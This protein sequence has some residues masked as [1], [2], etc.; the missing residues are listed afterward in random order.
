MFLLRRLVPEKVLGGMQWASEL[1]MKWFYTSTDDD[2]VVHTAKL[3]K[4]F[5]E[6]ITNSYTFPNNTINFVEVPIV[7][8][9]SYQSTDL[10]NKN[11]W[12]KWYMPFKDYSGWFWPVYCRG[13]AYSTTNYMVKN[14]YQASRKTPRLYLDDVWVTGFMRLKLGKLSNKIAVGAILL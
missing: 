6:L 2:I 10:A 11:P 13:G 12:S 7:C 8:M 5:K 14:L 9:Y 1:P 4:Y 3:A